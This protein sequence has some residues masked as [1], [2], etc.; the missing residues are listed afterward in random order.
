[1]FFFFFFFSFLCVWGW[2]VMKLDRWTIIHLYTHIFI[3]Y[4]SYCKI[5]GSSNDLLEVFFSFF[6][7]FFFFFL[8]Y[9]PSLNKKVICDFQREVQRCFD[10]CIEGIKR[11]ACLPK[12]WAW[13]RKLPWKNATIMNWFVMDHNTHIHPYIYRVL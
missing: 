9:G 10:L 4:Y 2:I 13:P 8:T 5:I 11:W 12:K 7:F 1:M 6:L 3:G